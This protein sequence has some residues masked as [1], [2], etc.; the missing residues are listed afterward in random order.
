VVTDGQWRMATGGSWPSITPPCHTTWS[1][2]RRPRRGRGA[3]AGHAVRDRHRERCP[4]G[5]R[6]RG[7][8]LPPHRPGGHLQD[9]LGTLCL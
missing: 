3:S 6:Q 8:F 5:P 9:R 2:C 4:G 7:K 1:S